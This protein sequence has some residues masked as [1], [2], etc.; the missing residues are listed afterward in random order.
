M[1]LAAIVI[2][3]YNTVTGSFPDQTAVVKIN[4]SITTGI[5]NVNFDASF[6]VFPNPAK[7]NV[8]VKLH[9]STN[10]NCTVEI[11]NEVGQIERLINFGNDSEISNNISISNLAAGIYVCKTTLGD[12]VSIRKLII[13]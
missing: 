3:E 4:S 12:K 1:K 9:N 5:N 7:N 10:A 8:N 11:I 2:V 13:E 6:N